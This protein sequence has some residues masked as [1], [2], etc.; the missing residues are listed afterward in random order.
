MDVVVCDI[1][2]DGFLDTLTMMSVAWTYSYVND[3]WLEWRE[4]EASKLFCYL[5]TH[6]IVV[7]HNFFG[8]DKPALEKITGLTWTANIFDT[9]VGA[10]LRNPDIMGGHSLRAWGKRLGILKG[11]VAEDGDDDIEEVYG[12]YTHEL[13]VYCKDDVKVTDALLKSLI[14]HFDIEELNFNPIDWE[15]WKV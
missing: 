9:M 1:E 2:T 11:I 6:A 15:A 5:N 14:K 8:F 7:G 4:K 10:R 13:S 12:V 3:E